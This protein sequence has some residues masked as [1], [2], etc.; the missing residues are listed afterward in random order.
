MEKQSIINNEVISYEILIDISR[1]VYTNKIYD[2]T[3][4]EIKKN[5]GLLSCSL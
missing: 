5:E 2:V 3:I 4:I 1:K